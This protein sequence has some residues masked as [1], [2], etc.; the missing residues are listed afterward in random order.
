M[1]LSPCW[2]ACDLR[3]CWHPSTGPVHYNIVIDCDETLYKGFTAIELQN[4][5]SQLRL[6]A[7]QAVFIN[8]LPF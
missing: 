3:R 8:E 1:S 6:V 5:L 4:L 7:Q 2:W